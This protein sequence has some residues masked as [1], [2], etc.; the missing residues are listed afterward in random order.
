MSAS[1]GNIIY[2]SKLIDI[3]PTKAKN[4]N[5]LFINEDTDILSLKNNKN[6]FLFTKSTPVVPGGGSQGDGNYILELALGG[7][8]EPFTPGQLFGTIFFNTN[9]GNCTIKIVDTVY[10]LL[11]NEGLE[12]GIGKIKAGKGYLI[13]FSINAAFNEFCFRIFLDL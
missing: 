3:T 1:Q 2:K 11:D 8:K 5:T 12:I 6:E 4:S 10:K 13:G 7:I 9:I